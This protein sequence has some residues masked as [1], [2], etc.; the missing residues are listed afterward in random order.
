MCYIVGISGFVCRSVQ[1]SEN[2]APVPLLYHVFDSG[3]IDSIRDHSCLFCS[4]EGLIKEP[5]K[6]PSKLNIVLFRQGNKVIAKL[7][8]GKKVI[9]TTEAKCSPED[10]FNF[11]VG[12]QIALQRLMA[13]QVDYE[14]IIYPVPETTGVSE[15]LLY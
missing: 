5:V 6:E 10:P 8:E 3:G 15:F 4:E 11:F 13:E 12:A 14:D 7:T 9:N 1:F 2:T